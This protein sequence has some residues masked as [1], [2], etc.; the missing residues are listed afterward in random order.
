MFSATKVVTLIRP[1]FLVKNIIRKNKGSVKFEPTF[2]YAAAKM[3]IFI[4]TAM[5]S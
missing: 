5:K 3:R 4:E 1:N 2:S